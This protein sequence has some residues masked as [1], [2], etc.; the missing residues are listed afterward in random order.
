MGHNGAL[1]VALHYNVDANAG[2][3]ATPSPIDAENEAPSNRPSDDH[4][5]K[6][7]ETPHKSHEHSL[8]IALDAWRGEVLWRKHTDLEK[9]D[10]VHVDEVDCLHHYEEL[11]RDKSV[12]GIYLDSEIS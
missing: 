6:D 2:A 8:Y 12:G 10:G 3:G 7:K 1:I 9:T 5:D 11:I 4:H